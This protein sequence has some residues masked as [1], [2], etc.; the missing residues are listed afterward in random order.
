MVGQK[1]PNVWGLYDLY[2]NVQEWC[3]DW[4]DS[5]YYDYSPSYNPTGPDSGY[6]KGIRGGFSGGNV[7]Y[8]RSAYRNSFG[9]ERRIRFI[10]FRIVRNSR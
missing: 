7:S 9:P 6:T 4:C 2:G 1:E 8:C 5:Y 3:N 10:G